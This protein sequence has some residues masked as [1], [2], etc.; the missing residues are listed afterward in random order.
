LET[1]VGGPDSSKDKRRQTRLAATIAGAAVGLFAFLAYL[2]TLAPGVLRY[3]RPALL[4]P[5]MLQTQAHSLGITH[6]T[7]YPTWTLVTHLFTRLPFESPAYWANLASAVWATAA[8]VFVYLI[9]LRLVG[10]VIPAVAAALAFGAGETFWSQALIAEVYTMNAMFVAAVVYVLLLWRDSGR[11]RYLLLAAFLTGLSLT[12]HLTSGLLLPAGLLFVWLVRREKLRRWG[13]MLK[14][15]ALFCLALMPYLYLPIR[16][17]MQPEIMEAD[18]SAS[19]GSFFEFAT[20]TKLTSTIVSLRPSVLASDVGVY[21]GHLVA[22]LHWA[23]VLLAACG[24]GAMF[25]RDR[26]A[27]LLTGFL[28]AGW[29]VYALMYNIHN[30]Y[31]YFIPTYAMLAIWASAGIGELLRGVRALVERFPTDFPGGL[32]KAATL[33]VSVAVLSLPLVGAADT[34]ATV[35]RSQDYK[36]RQTIEMVAEEAEPGATIIHHRSAL[37]YMVVVE[38]RRRD[39]TLVDPFYPEWNEHHDTVWPGIVE[40]AEADARY[41]TDDYSGMEAARIAAE[42]GPVYILDHEEFFDPERYRAAGFEI[43]EVSEEGQGLYRLIPPDP[44]PGLLRN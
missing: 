33:L 14:A 2:A 9:C 27:A 7:G 38:D 37:W 12:H 5:V 41:G 20:G 16:A 44:P 3:E 30:I 31:I 6:P 39:L 8:V 29:F 42:D 26:A 24:L 36:G 13:L 1:R 28:F 25:A 4:D 15:A 11:D 34:H 22:N 35:D 17:S 10:R 19:F 43:I 18:P 40:P 21:A 32:A 23:F